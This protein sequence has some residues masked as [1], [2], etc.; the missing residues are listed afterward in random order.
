LNLE[1]DPIRVQILRKEKL[2]YISEVFFIVQGEEACLMVMMNEPSTEGATC[3]PERLLSLG[4]Q[5]LQILNLA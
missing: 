2:P 3:F 5:I 1:Y 4:I